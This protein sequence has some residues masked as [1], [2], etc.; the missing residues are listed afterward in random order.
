MYSAAA[1]FSDRDGDDAYTSLSIS[2]WE[3]PSAIYPEAVLISGL[4]FHAPA[5][6]RLALPVGAGREIETG[7]RVDD[8]FASLND[9]SCG[10]TRTLGAWLKRLVSPSG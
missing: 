8:R 6:C 2:R 4:A 3:S 5:A 9:V 10:T 7:W 1:T